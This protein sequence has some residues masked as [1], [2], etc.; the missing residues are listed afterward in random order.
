MYELE[1]SVDFN[2]LAFSFLKRSLPVYAIDNFSIRPGKTKDIVMEL[3]DIPYKI[4]GYRDFPET[5]VATVVN[6]RLKQQGNT[7]LV[8][9]NEPPVENDT[10]IVPDKDEDPYPWLDKED[11]RRNMTD[12]EILEKYVDLS[13]SDLNVA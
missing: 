13:D 1:A 6:K 5:G 7:K 9:R 3:R 4:T 2:N 10:N 12:Q 8:D 11:P